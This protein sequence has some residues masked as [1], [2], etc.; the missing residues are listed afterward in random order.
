[1]LSHAG[2]APFVKECGHR[3][4]HTG[5]SILKALSFLESIHVD[6]KCFR[7][8]C[9]VGSLQEHQDLTSED[10]FKDKGF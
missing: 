7:N 9:V 10:S 3:L 5:Q 8:I 1:M 6:I 2:S 4:T